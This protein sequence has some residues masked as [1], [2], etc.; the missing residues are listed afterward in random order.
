MES[1][2]FNLFSQVRK[3]V[4]QGLGA[5]YKLSSHFKRILNPYK[6]TSM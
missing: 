1:N 5:P 2:E 4:E 6:R 3:I